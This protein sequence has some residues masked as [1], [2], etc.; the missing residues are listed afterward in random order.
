[1]DLFAEINL[2]Q[3]NFHDMDITNFGTERKAKNYGKTK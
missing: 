2:W 1:M 3:D